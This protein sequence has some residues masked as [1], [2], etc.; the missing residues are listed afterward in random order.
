MHQERVGRSCRGFSLT[1]GLVAASRRRLV[2][3]RRKKVEMKTL[4]EVWVDGFA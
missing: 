1:G 3:E 2:E 4:F